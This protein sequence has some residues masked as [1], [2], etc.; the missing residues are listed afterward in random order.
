VLDQVAQDANR[1]VG[2]H[3]DSS[4][5]IDESGCPKKGKPSVGVARQ[6]TDFSNN[7]FY[8]QPLR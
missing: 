1:H 4:F 5:I 3:P 2:D 8:L 7:L 6:K